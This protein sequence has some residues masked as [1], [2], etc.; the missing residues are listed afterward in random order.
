MSVESEQDATA[1]SEGS[2]TVSK[3]AFQND[4][5]IWQVSSL[6][7]I[8]PPAVPC[9]VLSHFSDNSIALLL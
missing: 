8:P 7:V 4:A 3:Q 1:T 2:K 6:Q 5:P 9:H